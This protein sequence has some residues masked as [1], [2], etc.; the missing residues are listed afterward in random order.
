MN[1][2]NGSLDL[3]NL[4]DPPACLVQKEL[5][6]RSKILDPQQYAD[7]GSRKNSGP[8]AMCGSRKIVDPQQCTGKGDLLQFAGPE[9][10]VDPHECEIRE[11][12]VD[13]AMCGFKQNS[14]PTHSNLRV[15]NK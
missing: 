10:I 8:S 6:T 14:G 9:K 1:L 5:R 7:C 12:I 13:P 11:E 2:Q 4:V 3:E 15:E